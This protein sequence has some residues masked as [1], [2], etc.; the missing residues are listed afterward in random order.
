MAGL[1]FVEWLPDPMP[2]PMR[3][4]DGKLGPPVPRG[5]RVELPGRG[6]VFVR[7]VSGPS[8][9]PTIVLLHGWM[10]S[11]GLNWFQAFEALGREFHVLAPDLRGHAR[12]LRAR[13][14]RLEDC[15]DDVAALCRVLGV[16]PVLIAGYSMGGPVAQLLWQRHPHVVAGLV[17]CATT[18]TFAFGATEGPAAQHVLNTLAAGARLVESVLHV[19][20][21]A[22]RAVIP[23]RR[24][25]DFVQW[26]TAELTRHS[27]HMLTEAACSVAAYR[28]DEWM[29]AVN[30]PTA[31]VLTTR[32]RS[33]PPA[34]QLQMAE[35]IPYST[36]HPVDGGHAACVRARFVEPLLDA[37]CTV[38]SPRRRLSTSPG[39]CVFPGREPAG[40]DRAMAGTRRPRGQRSV[41]AHEYA[42]FPKDRTVEVSD[43]TRVAFTVLGGGGSKV[44]VLFLNGWTCTDA[45]W[46]TIPTA[47]AA[48]GHPA[49]L[50]DLRGHAESGLPRR[51][52]VA[53]RSLHA[54]DVSAVRLARD[55]VEVMDAAGVRQ[56][57]LVGHSIGVQIIVEVCRIAPERVAG[58]VAVAGAFENP[59]K[60]LTDPALLD[61]LYPIAQTLLDYLPLEVLRPVLRRVATPTLG[62]AVAR[63]VGAAGPKV[64]PQDMAPHMR[65]IG[66][67]NFSVLLKML[68]SLRAHRTA[69]FLP[70]ITAPTLVVAAGGDVFTPPRVPQQMADAVPGAEIVWFE[71]A[72]HLLP[73]EEPDAVTHALLNFLAESVTDN[74]K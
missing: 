20:A 29:G 4:A 69:E 48:A 24:P 62:R 64:T 67:L 31:V 33:V 57:V 38:A 37:C 10:A 39:P 19:P 23:A 1:S 45:Y 54:E 56:A 55:V 35:A 32:D 16:D 34:M 13:R 41:R 50:M 30:V 73:V 74:E 7:E 47:V 44:P 53:A 6:S 17:L 21:D 8:G 59:I 28:A 3:H 61:Q 63:A 40:A 60:T 52:G 22:L 25:M 26:A 9:A 65:H 43:G 49:V 27:V 11:G 15:A 2:G 5:R 58:L 18:H 70:Q 68:T 72:G 46:T 36:V 66:D 42:L 71:N 14:F 51:P 12:G